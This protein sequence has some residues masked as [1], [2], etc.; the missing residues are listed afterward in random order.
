VLDATDNK[1][2]G[3]QIR[4]VGSKNKYGVGTKMEWTFYSC[5]VTNL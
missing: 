4:G 2:Q 5:V 1:W 3:F